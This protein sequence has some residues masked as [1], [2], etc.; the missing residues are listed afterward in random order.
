MIAMRILTLTLWKFML[1]R[2]SCKVV[3]SDTQSL[4]AIVRIVSGLVVII[5]IIIVLFH[6]VSSLPKGCTVFLIQ[7]SNF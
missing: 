3:L 2:R 1:G 6:V 4:S 7:I 5:N